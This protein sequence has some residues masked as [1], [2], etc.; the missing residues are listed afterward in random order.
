MT[1]KRTFTEGGEDH[2]MAGLQSAFDLI[3]Q[4]VL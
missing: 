4:I 2:G 1:A 3:R